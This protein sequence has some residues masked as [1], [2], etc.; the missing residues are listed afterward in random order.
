MK[1][2]VDLNIILDYLEDRAPFADEAE[3]FIADKSN[4]LFISALMVTHSK[5][6]DFLYC[7]RSAIS[8]SFSATT[9]SIAA[10]FLSRYAAI[11]RCSGSGGS[12]KL[13]AP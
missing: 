2:F 6:S 13:I 3:N 5:I 8:P 11:A 12:G 1:I 7:S 4:Q 10:H 9:R